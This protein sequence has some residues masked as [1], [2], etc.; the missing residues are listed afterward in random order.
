[1]VI[2]SVTAAT[3]EIVFN[4]DQTVTFTSS[5]DVILLVADG[6]LEGFPPV[7]YFDPF[8]T[9]IS[10]T[11]GSFGGFVTQV[12]GVGFDE[13]TP[14]V[15]ILSSAYDDSIC[16]DDTVEITG[17]GEFI[18]TVV[19]E[20]EI[21]ANDVSSLLANGDPFSCPSSITGL[22]CSFSGA[23]ASSPILTS[24]TIRSPTE[25]V[26]EEAV[27]SDQ[28]Y[29]AICIFNGLDAAVTYEETSDGSGVYNVICTFT[30]GIPAVDSPEPIDLIYFPNS[31]DR[32]DKVFAIRNSVTVTN[33]NLVVPD[34][35]QEY[36]CSYAGGCTYT[37]YGNYLPGALLADPVNNYVLV[38]DA[39]KCPLIVALSDDFKAVCKL[40]A[41]TDAVIVAG[42]T[43]DCDIDVYY[44]DTKQKSLEQ[45][46]YV[47]AS[48]PSLTSFTPLYGT[49]DGGTE[50]TFTG[51]YLD[52]T[53]T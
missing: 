38:C 26:L 16:I 1:M 7:L 46:K 15:G 45:A 39:L 33:D 27:L 11:A 43:T 41:L 50:V 5:D 30:P 4:L 32:T 2:E 24:A 23:E 12:S 34:T 53:K 8:I 17:Y 3:D 10:L 28:S 48:T 47:E 20:I 9:A 6:Q 21:G 40:P 35:P 51:D 37:V 31:P 18:C 44:D 13:T 29:D 49:I 52:S 36:D 14:S 22:S 25:I 19:P 42:G